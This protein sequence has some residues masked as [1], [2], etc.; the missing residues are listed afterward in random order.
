MQTKMIHVSCNKGW[1]TENT[2]NLQMRLAGFNI[3]HKLF[4]AKKG[5]FLNTNVGIIRNS[6]I[7][8][9]RVLLEDL[10]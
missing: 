4:Q 3:F 9:G 2:V 6:G 10:R 7:I 5:G 1:I 8:G